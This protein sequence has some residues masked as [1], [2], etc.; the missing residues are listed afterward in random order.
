MYDT[1]HLPPSSL[2]WI[3]FLQISRRLDALL[4]LLLLQQHTIQ[5]RISASQIPPVAICGRHV[6]LQ[7]PVGTARKLGTG[8]ALRH[9][10]S[11][12]ATKLFQLPFQRFGST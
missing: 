10:I 2:F 9:G 4:L 3:C 6:Q 5:T 11:L 7:C 8:T 12:H 1:K